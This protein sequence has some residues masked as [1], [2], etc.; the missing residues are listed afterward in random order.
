M[1]IRT[2]VVAATAVSLSLV[3]A[4]SAY[5]FNGS[6]LDSAASPQPAETV[7]VE[8]PAAPVASPVEVVATQAVEPVAEAIAATNTVDAVVADTVSPDVVTPEPVAAPASHESY[9]SDDSYE[10]DET[11]SDDSYESDETDHGDSAE[12][13]EADHGDPVEHAESGADLD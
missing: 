10:N 8:L 11:E 12:H 6:V 3:G 13:A 2:T 1:K 7:V 5:A 9:E 4:T